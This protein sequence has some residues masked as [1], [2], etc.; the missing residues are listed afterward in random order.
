LLSLLFVLSLEVYS[1][2]LLRCNVFDFNIVRVEREEAKV[3]AW[4]GLQKPKAEAAI[5]KLVA[6]LH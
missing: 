1:F 4:D 3:T 2:S 5:Q 6:C